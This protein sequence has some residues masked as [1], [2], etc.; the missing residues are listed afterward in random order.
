MD[1]CFPLG[2]VKGRSG[3]L[4]TNR[5]M[6]SMGFIRLSRISRIFVVYKQRRDV[7][8]NRLASLQMTSGAP[9][10]LGGLSYLFRIRNNASSTVRATKVSGPGEVIP[11]TLDASFGASL[12]K[13][14][15]LRGK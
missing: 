2:N 1:E 8:S 5:S 11:I 3:M 12:C 9:L 10:N 6:R 13:C 14:A 4:R 15:A 7:E